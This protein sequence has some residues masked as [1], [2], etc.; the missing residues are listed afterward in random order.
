MATIKIIH[1]IWLDTN[2][3]R[4]K[5]ANG[6]VVPLHKRQGDM[7]GACAVYSLA[8]AMLCIG[9][10]T[11]DDLDI[12]NHPDRR[13]PKGKLLSH[14]LDEQGLVRG[15]YCFKTMAQE[16]RE[17][18]FGIDVTRR[19]PKENV[20]IINGIADYLDKDYPVIISTD[21]DG[22]AHALLAVGYETGDDDDK[23]TKLFCLDPSGE[24]PLYSYWNCVINVSRTSGKARYPFD[25]IS[26][27]QPYKVALGD[28]LVLMKAE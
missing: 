10:V 3:V 8:M 22:G 13:T 14:F 18:N 6:K 15:G 25:Y 4:V 20:D 5:D 12:Y 7:D 23:V 2:G 11:S 21:F 26:Q 17:S 1:S 27:S 16:I 9:A 28:F 19:A 24:A